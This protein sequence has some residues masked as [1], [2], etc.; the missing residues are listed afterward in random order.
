[1]SAITL[2]VPD[3]I[4][5]LFAQYKDRLPEIV[6]R[7]IRGVQDEAGA[8]TS[9]AK[10]EGTQDIFEFLASL[11]TPEEILKLEA[12][13]RLQQRVHALLEKNRNEKLSAREEEEMDHYELVEHLVRLAKIKAAGKLGLGSTKHA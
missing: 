5:G 6:E 4:A 10:Y 8:G 11:P 13:E 9:F 7:I 2:Q 12:S 3:D 1:M